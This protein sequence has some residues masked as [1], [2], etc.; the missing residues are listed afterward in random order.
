MQKYCKVATISLTIL[1]ISPNNIGVEA[2]EF[3]A[4]ALSNYR[5]KTWKGVFVKLQQLA[6]SWCADSL[7]SIATLTCVGL[8][9]NNIDGDSSMPTIQYLKTKIAHSKL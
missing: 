5:K 1:N 8:S 6:Y 2:A 9:N 3:I 7:Q 4:V